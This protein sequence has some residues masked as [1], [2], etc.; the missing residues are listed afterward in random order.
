MKINFKYLACLCVFGAVSANSALAADAACLVYDND[1]NVYVEGVSYSG[2]AA[3]ALL[4][5]KRCGCKQ[6][7]APEGCTVY[8]VTSNCEDGSNGTSCF[9]SCSFEWLC[10]DEANDGSDTVTCA[11]ITPPPKPEPQPAP[12]PQPT[13]KPGGG[14][15]AR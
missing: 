2:E 11:T 6:P 9:G 10:E 8:L 7:E 4:A 12:E 5:D 15:S 3:I 14:Q 13:P 1:G